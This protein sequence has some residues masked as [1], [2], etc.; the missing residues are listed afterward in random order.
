LTALV[1]PEAVAL[2]NRNTPV[3]EVSI[4]D[5]RNLVYPLLIFLSI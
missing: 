5:G 3:L 2:D 4:E 1:S